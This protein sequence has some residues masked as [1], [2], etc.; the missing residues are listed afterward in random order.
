[1][2]YGEGCGILGAVLSRTWVA[3]KLFRQHPHRIFQPVHGKLVHA[4]LHQLLYHTDALEVLPYALG[5]GQSA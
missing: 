1:L 5:Y 4:L 2:C 3:L